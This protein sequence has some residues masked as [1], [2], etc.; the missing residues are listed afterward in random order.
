MTSARGLTLRPLQKLGK[1]GYTAARVSRIREQ[2]KAEERIAEIS[3][4]EPE[5]AFFNSEGTLAF[6]GGEKCDLVGISGP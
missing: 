1:D 5:V 3:Q 2:R 4:C 6:V